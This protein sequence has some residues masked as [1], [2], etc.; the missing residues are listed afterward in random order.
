MPHGFKQLVPLDQ[1]LGRLLEAID[2]IDRAGR[3]PI[4]E[5]DD[6]IVAEPVTAPTDLPREDR[7]AMDGYAVLA[8]DTH[9]ASERAPA[10]LTID[11]RAGPGSAVRVHTGAPLPEGADAVVMLEEAEAAGDEL[12]VFTAVQTGRH[13][14][15]RGEDVV[16]GRTLFERG[17]RL[18]PADLALLRAL[19]VG[20]VPVVDRPEVTAVPTGDEIVDAEPGPGQSVESNG[21]A[22][23]ALLERWGADV[24]R[25]GIV[26]DDPDALADAVRSADGDLVATIGG[27]SVGARDRLPEMLDGIGERLFHGVRLRPGHPVGAWLVDDRPVVTLPG[28][29]VAC[30]VTATLLVR[31]AVRKLGRRP[32]PPDPTVRAELSRKVPSKVGDRQIVRV[33]LERTDDGWTA[34]PTRSKGA[35]VIS[36]LT[37][38]DGIVEVP[39][40]TEGLP[41]G[42]EVEV[43]IW[44]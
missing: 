36:S 2:P 31:P 22:V 37:T 16:E 21:V 1:A 28:Y 3:V 39:E 40:R 44:T 14:A 41:G 25:T 27:T 13:V 32:S 26:P 17:H 9:G 34:H 29:P 38:A 5:A 4:A 6:R 33:E 24:D 10:E 23:V 43:V 7:A 11:D 15:D 8:E 18:R 35:G 12:T 20:T 30:L 19:E 42:R